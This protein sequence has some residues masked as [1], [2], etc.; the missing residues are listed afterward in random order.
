MQNTTSSSLEMEQ[1]ATDPAYSYATNSCKQD[2]QNEDPSKDNACSYWKRNYVCIQKCMI[3]CTT[4]LL[5][6]VSGYTIVSACLIQSDGFKLPPLLEYLS[7]PL[8]FLTFDCLGAY[9]NRWDWFLIPSL[10]IN[11]FILCWVIYTPYHPYE[12]PPYDP[13][14]GN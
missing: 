12:N 5:G 9:K 11:M 1:K 13:Y 2:Q 6:M 3:I 4:L 8:V 7:G 10:L 14:Y